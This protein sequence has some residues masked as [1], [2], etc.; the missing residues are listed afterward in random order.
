MEGLIPG[1]VILD[2]IRAVREE[3]RD[4]R[5]TVTGWRQEMGERVATIETQIRPAILGN[6]QPSRLAVVESHVD[7]LRRERW[8]LAGIATGVSG[9][10]MLVLELFRKKLGL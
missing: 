4:F 6:G 10:F 2:E 7:D 8:R 5:E 1:N 3:L 9:L